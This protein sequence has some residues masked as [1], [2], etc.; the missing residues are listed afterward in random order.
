MKTYLYILYFLLL[1]NSNLFSTTIIFDY[2]EPNIDSLISQLPKLNLDSNKVNLLIE[3]AQKYNKYNS[4][5]I[6]KGIKYANQSLE[7][8]KQ[9]NWKE[10]QIKS[11]FQLGMLYDDI[12]VD[13]NKAIEYYQNTL[14]ISKEIRNEY[15]EF[16]SLLF[17]GNTYESLTNYPKA[18]EYFE[19]GLEKAEKISKKIDNNRALFLVLRDLFSAYEKN[20]DYKKAFEA[21]ERYVYLVDYTRISENYT[22]IDTL[23]LKIE[24]ELREKEIELINK[25]K[26]IE[27]L[28]IYIMYGG[29][30]GLVL[31]IALAI[32]LIF[33]FK[34][35]SK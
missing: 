13:Y 29:I 4:N 11:L 27:K 21:C 12:N 34:R 28:M 1:I 18:I 7:L 32:F 9:I 6:K 10:G 5:D 35:V 22:E 24:N 14:K 30:S 31:I 33:A 19:I 16:G 3:I 23:K 2:E 8:S 17:I 25:D 20:S 15:Y 26:E